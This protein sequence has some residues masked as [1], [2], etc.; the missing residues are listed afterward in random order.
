MALFAEYLD[1]NSSIIELRELV[2]GDNFQTCDL[3]RRIG[4][5]RMILQMMIDEIDFDALFSV[6]ASE[7][8][9][10]KTLYLYYCKDYEK[11]LPFCDEGDPDHW[12]SG[13]RIQMFG[14]LFLVSKNRHGVYC[15]FE[16][17]MPEIPGHKC[18][19][20][21]SN[22]NTD[23]AK[24]RVLQ[25][26]NKLESYGIYIY[27][28][29]AYIKEIEMNVNLFFTEHNIDFRDAV[30]LIRPFR[31]NLRNFKFSDYAENQRDKYEY[32]Y[33][34]HMERIWGDEAHIPVWR[35]TSFNAA[36]RTLEIKVYDKS[37]ETLKNEGSRRLISEISPIT[38]VEFTLRDVNQ[39]QAYFRNRNLFDLEQS[40]IE[41]VF[42]RIALRYMAGPLNAYYRQLTYALESYFESIDITAFAW[43]KNAV[44]DLDALLKRTDDIIVLPYSEIVRLVKLIKA[45]SIKSNGSRIA[46]SFCEEIRKSSSS[47]R[48]TET[49]TVS[50]LMDWL[51]T[52]TG[53]EDQNIF[54][55][56]NDA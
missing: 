8:G 25:M 50:E 12:I 40:D 15:T 33:S 11:A 26:M 32:I 53:E 21:I 19:G 54:Y 9:L 24:A 23:Q 1:E 2:E 48:I 6:S 51:C 52:H 37:L 45:P 42:H 22:M 28:D 17:F 29:V 55:V 31:H 36:R 18:L 3:P 34:S 30:D 39:V 47:I 43:R 49:D 38:R 10:T 41:R 20:N 56:L 35:R 7:E 4:I 27:R 13:L 46:K 16:I 14:G 44:L 5:D